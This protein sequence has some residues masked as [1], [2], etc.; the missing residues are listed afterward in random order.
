MS[1]DRSFDQREPPLL[2]SGQPRD[3]DTS[4]IK[5]ARVLSS[6]VTS[7][8]ERMESWGGDG[9]RVRETSDE[10]EERPGAKEGGEGQGQ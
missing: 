1:R 10:G 3:F 9:D 8:V 5:E 2:F 6:C 4:A 7:R